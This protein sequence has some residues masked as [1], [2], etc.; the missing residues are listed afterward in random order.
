MSKSKTL[1]IAARRRGMSPTD[2]RTLVG[3]AVRLGGA[4]W[5]KFTT[6]ADAWEAA[7]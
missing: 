1:Y 3:A 4:Q 2:A 7:Q 5:R 6:W